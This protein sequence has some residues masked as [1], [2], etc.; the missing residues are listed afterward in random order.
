METTTVVLEHVAGWSILEHLAAPGQ[1]VLILKA[2]YKKV[3]SESPEGLQGMKLSLE[4]SFK[5][6]ALWAS[7]LKDA[8][9]ESLS[10]RRPSGLS[11]AAFL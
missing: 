6:E 9:G 1:K 3:A 11:G 8:Q 7:D 10:P 4:A 2:S 5:S